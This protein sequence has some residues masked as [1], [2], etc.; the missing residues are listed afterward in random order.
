KRTCAPAGAAF[1]CSKATN[2]CEIGG[3]YH[4]PG[5]PAG[6]LGSCVVAQTKRKKRPLCCSDSACADCQSDADCV[7]ELNALTARCIKQCDFC[8]Q[9]GT[10]T[11]C[12]VPL[13]DS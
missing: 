7:T 1:G 12:V 6:T 13:T 9:F 3:L 11:M 10:T 4:C 8:V 2:S 5:L